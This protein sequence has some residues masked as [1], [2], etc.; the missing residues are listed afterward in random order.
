M[1]LEEELG[2]WILLTTNNEDVALSCCK[3]LQH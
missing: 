1:P 3:S 2:A